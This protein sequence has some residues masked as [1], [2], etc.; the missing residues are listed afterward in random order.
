MPV[1][2][3]C[4]LVVSCQ[5]SLDLSPKAYMSSGTFYKSETDA[6]ASLIGA[7]SVL[8]GIYRNEHILTPNEICADNAI[9]F[10]TGGPDRVAIWRYEHNSMNLYPG[11][12]WSSAYQGIQYCNVVIDRVPLIDMNEQLKSQFI[13]EARFL[14]ALHY[15]N[16]VRFFGG[17]P[18]VLNETISLDNV[19]I[20]RST[21]D[22]VYEAIEADLKSAEATLPSARPADETGRATSGTA[23]GLLAKVYLTRAGN[24]SAS[25]Y[26]S[27][28][29]QKAREVMDSN[30]YMLW[31]NYE[32]VFRLEN[33]GGKESLFEVLFVTDLYGNGFTTGY[34]PR[35]APIVPSGGFGIFRVTASLF[36]EYLEKDK[37][38]AVT[39]LTSY[40][41][42]TTRD[43]IKLSVEN[44]DPALA[45]SFR[46]L[47]DPTVK[48]GLN[49]GTS[50]PYMRYS[51]ILLIYAEALN[52][53]G[54]GPAVE[55]YEA[56]NKVR[57]RA[58]LT[59]LSGLSR[60][61]FREAVLKER[62]L[63]LSFEGHRWFDLARTGKLLDAVRRENSFGRNAPVK[64]FHLLFPIPFR[65]IEANHL[66]RQNDGY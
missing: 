59:E 21:I 48:V 60:D 43:T 15:F 31:D 19:E 53:S 57:R 27:M 6:K 38:K 37:R 17:V 5:T 3:C 54:N 25:P 35:G 39:F 18:L 44:P 55:A 33:R 50:W 36:N 56:L 40:V 23:K 52:E 34:A 65:E 7:Y 9:P 10:L 61:E 41:H 49:G 30:L 28:A 64:D 51:E 14:R 1:T 58:G 47:A 8:Y 42:P 13:A 24:N 46:K 22:E 2:I 66:L 12:I 26:W 16:L 11:Q 62:R 32:D 29:A 45:V 4:L 20:S 63:E